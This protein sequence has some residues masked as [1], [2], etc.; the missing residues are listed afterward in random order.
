MF[1]K[2]ISVML[3]GIALGGCSGFKNPFSQGVDDTVLPGQRTNVL[4]ENQQV[5]NKGT[6]A[7]TSAAKP[8]TAASTNNKAVLGLPEADCE[9]SNPDYPECLTPPDP[10]ATDASVID[11]EATVAQ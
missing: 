1:K 11:E 3:V 6:L 9:P 5:V 4:D 2:T 8:A 10:N 7:N